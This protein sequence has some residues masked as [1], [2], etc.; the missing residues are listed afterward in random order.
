MNLEIFLIIIG[1]AIAAGFVTRAAF[2]CCKRLGD[3]A[4]LVGYMDEA[5]RQDDY[6]TSKI[7]THPEFAAAR[8]QLVADARNHLQPLLDKVE[9]GRC[10]TQA[11]LIMA[12]E[13]MDRTLFAPF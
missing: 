13:T 4:W 10:L 7:P 11:E 3:K 5:D 8:L 1:T 2:K 9:A 12:M 6:W